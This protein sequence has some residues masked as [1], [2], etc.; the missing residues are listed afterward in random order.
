MIRHHN[1]GP[2]PVQFGVT[3]KEGILNQGRN[4]GFTKPSR[5]NLGPIEDRI[6]FREQFLVLIKFEFRDFLSR[7]FGFPD[8]TLN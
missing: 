1:I 3:S 7:C 2:Q 4:L 8:L 6:K 5:A